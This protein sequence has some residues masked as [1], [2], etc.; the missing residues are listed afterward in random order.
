[1]TLVAPPAASTGCESCLERA[2]GWWLYL[3]RC[4]SCGHVG[5]CDA[6]PSRHASE[7]ARTTGHSI[8]VSFEPGE[9]WYW[10]Y[11][12]DRYVLGQRRS[13]P[14]WRP[15]SQPSPA[16]ADRVPPTWLARLR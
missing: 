6:S 15:A 13:E 2:D 16:P 10:N 9:H 1:M 5:C 4:T 7:H 8:V 14:L 12:S 11:E 3:R